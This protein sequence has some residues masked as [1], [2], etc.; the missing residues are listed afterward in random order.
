MVKTPMLLELLCFGMT[1]G[2]F[3]KIL[4]VGGV[5]AGGMLV[6]IVFGHC[7]SFFLF[8]QIGT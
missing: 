1:C 5:E 2:D 8:L 6:E 4:E 3:L 7:L